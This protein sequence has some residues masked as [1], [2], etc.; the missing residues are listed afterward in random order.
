[1][2]TA[3]LNK[4]NYAIIYTPQDNVIYISHNIR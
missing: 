2:Q 1:M 3:D 4:L